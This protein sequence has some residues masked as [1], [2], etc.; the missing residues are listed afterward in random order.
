MNKLTIDLNH[1]LRESVWPGLGL[2]GESYLLFSIG[3]LKPLWTLLYPECFKGNTCSVSILHSLSYSVV[4]GV[5]VGMVVLGTA[6]NKIGRRKGSI[7]TAS[8][9]MMGAAA[10]ASIS[11][12]LSNYPSTLFLAMSWALALF[13][14][15]VGGEYPLSASSASERAM[16]DLKI[17]L[18]QEEAAAA[19]RA[20][21]NMTTSS[22]MDSLSNTLQ[23]SNNRGRRVQLVFTMQGMGI[24]VNSLSLVLLLLV[25]GQTQNV[26]NNITLLNI[27]RAIYAIG[28]LILGYVLVFRI[29][30]LE[31]SQTW[32]L[33]KE[34]REEQTKNRDLAVF[35]PPTV[36]FTTR[37]SSL[38][39]DTPLEVEDESRKQQGRRRQRVE[40][41]SFFT[42]EDYFEIQLFIKHFGFR[43]LGTCM[44]WFLWD[45]AFYGNKLF[46][47][48]FISA[49]IGQNTTLLNVSGGTVFSIFY[50][51]FFSFIYIRYRSKSS[52]YVSSLHMSCILYIAI[53]INAIVALLGY[54][55]AAILVDKVT[56]GRLRLQQ[57]GFLIAGLLFCICGWFKDLLSSFW[58]IVFYFGSSFF[59]QCGPNC[60]TFLIPAEVFPTEL[61]TMSHGISAAA[62]KAGALVA[63]IL[64]NFVTEKNLFLISGYCSFVGMVVT[65]ITIPETCT[66]DLYE[67]DKKW[68]CMLNGRLN[69]YYGEA[70][71]LRHLSL[72][73]R[74][75]FQRTP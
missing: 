20:T 15:G 59:G 7:L 9:M 28:A 57:Y 37:T 5:M 60:T 68:Q 42:V 29:L 33:D 74:W 17:R 12:F 56:V 75:R 14:I 36:A 39:T 23:D 48:S 2:F 73:E 47:S 70:N 24:F 49:L 25:T 71:D 27:W 13:G 53:T 52:T 10:M 66:L 19:H 50:L 34:Q 67:L 62:G 35:V 54:F 26:Y 46:Q 69:D 18:E 22:V 8:F 4:G 55:S 43:L 3:T 45:V 30:Y 32:K 58:L 51:S 41:H 21:A 16:M 38:S 65:W 40:T 72:I 31:E 63:A 1:Y 11:F 61:R 6:A 44:S 64:F